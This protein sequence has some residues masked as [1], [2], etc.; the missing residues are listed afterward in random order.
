MLYYIHFH[1]RVEFLL[2]TGSEYSK[3][4]KL[5]NS[6]WQPLGIPFALTPIGQLHQSPRELSS[7]LT[8]N[9]NFLGLFPQ[10]RV[11]GD[12]ESEPEI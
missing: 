11:Q 2:K 4:R 8:S 5:L 9:F 6:P 12:L 3:M 1:L 7:N 10:K